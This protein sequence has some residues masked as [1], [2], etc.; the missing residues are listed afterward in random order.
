MFNP[1]SEA[2]EGGALDAELVEQA[3][4]GDRSALENLVLRH[5]AWIFNIAVRMV[6]RPQDARWLYLY[7]RLLRI[8]RTKANMWP[9]ESLLI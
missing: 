1:F 6:F 7:R 5:Q 8:S 2:A 9:V 3:K 4:K